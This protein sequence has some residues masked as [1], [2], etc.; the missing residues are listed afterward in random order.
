MTGY[1]PRRCKV[2]GHGGDNTPPPPAAPVVEPE[3]KNIETEQPRKIRRPR[4][5]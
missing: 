5:P 3:D 1:T 2:V 4:T